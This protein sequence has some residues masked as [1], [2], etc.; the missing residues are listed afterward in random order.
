MVELL[1]KWLYYSIDVEVRR[2][3]SCG[4]E[5]RMLNGIYS[6]MFILYVEDRSEVIRLFSLTG[7]NRTR[8]TPADCIAMAVQMVS[9][10][11][12]PVEMEMVSLCDTMVVVEK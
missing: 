11:S 12:L 2:I 7:V 8:L 3:P 4:L 1:T 6:C 5:I 9:P 10:A